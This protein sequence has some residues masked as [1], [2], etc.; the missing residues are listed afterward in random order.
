MKPALGIDLGGTKIRAGL[1]DAAG[2][3]GAA[4]LC[5]TRS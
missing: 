5:Y 2:T 1:V 3:M 4:A